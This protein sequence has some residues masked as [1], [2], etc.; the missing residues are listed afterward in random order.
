MSAFFEAQFLVFRRHLHQS[1]QLK[2]ENGQQSHRY[3]RG[4]PQRAG[5]AAAVRQQLTGRDRSAHRHDDAADQHPEPH[6]DVARQF[7]HRDLRLVG[8]RLFKQIL[9]C[10]SSSERQKPQPRHQPS[11]LGSISCSWQRGHLSGPAA[12]RASGWTKSTWELIGASSLTNV[13]EI[14]L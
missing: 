8:L 2:G 9:A 7:P 11:P 1:E 3:L 12:R 10:S 13:V 4:G 14:V 5:E 6:G